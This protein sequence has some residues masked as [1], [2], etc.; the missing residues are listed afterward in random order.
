MGSAAKYSLVCLC[1]CLAPRLAA[2]QIVVNEIMFNP[3]GSDTGR[4]WVELYNPGTTDVAITGGSGKGSWR[5]ADSSNHTIADPASGTG[6]GTLSVPAG[7]Y[8]VIA[9]DPTEFISGEYAGGAYSVGKASL[10]LGNTGSSVSLID[11]SGA[12]VD[13]VS[14]TKD[15]GAAD[16]GA[17]LQRQAGGAWIAGTPT[18]GAANTTS[19]FVAPV[20]TSDAPI[21]STA[22][23]AAKT[24]PVVPSYVPPPVPKL[25]A[26]GGDDRSVIAGADTEYDGRAYNRDEEIIGNVRF[27]WNFGDGTTA[28]G[29]AVLHHYTYPGRYQV[30]LTIAENR[31][32]ASDH[33]VVTAEPAQLAFAANADGSITIE[34]RAG[35]DLDL[36][37]WIVRSFMQTFTLPADSIL[38]SGAALRLPETTLKFIAGPS[39]ELEYPNGVRALAAGESTAPAPV[40]AEARTGSAVVPVAASAP[41]VARAAPIIRAARAQTDSEDPGS[42]AVDAAPTSSAPIAQTA[43]AGAVFGGS[44]WWLAAALLGLFAAGIAVAARRAR[45]GEWKIEEAE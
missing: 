29:P 26:D 19:V 7:G 17:S 6:R 16:D 42:S 5:I 33:F 4:E 2:A 27:N 18:P 43:S 11:G 25:F 34:N 30:V 9:S 31:D 13:S 40:T 21:D 3:A 35:K 45:A 15:Q 32:A 28:E 20:S 1:V 8:L 37:S 14:Y 44:W 10:S 23:S 22:T 38:L 24:L 39:T 36:S 41:Q 12:V